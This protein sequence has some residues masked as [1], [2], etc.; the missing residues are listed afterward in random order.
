[1][2]AVVHEDLQ[3]ENTSSA[4]GSLLDVIVRDGARRMPAAALQAEVT[5]C[6]AAHADQVDEAGRRL[7][8]ATATTRPGR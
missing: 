5:A 8:C 4:G 1:M 7:W 3:P 2:L 6:S